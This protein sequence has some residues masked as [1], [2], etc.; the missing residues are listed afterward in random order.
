MKC[1]F[2]GR[3]VRRISSMSYAENPFCW[4]CYEDRMAIHLATVRTD[5]VMLENDGYTWW[6]AP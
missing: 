6:V 5:L 4:A 2:C 3:P 1:Q